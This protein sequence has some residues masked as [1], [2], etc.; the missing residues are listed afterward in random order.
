MERDFR[1]TTQCPS[2]TTDIVGD[3]F[4]G[5]N[6][7]NQKCLPILW[8]E[9]LNFE[10][11]QVEKS[12]S[13]MNMIW[14]RCGGFCRGYAMQNNISHHIMKGYGVFNEVILQTSMSASSVSKSHLVEPHP[15][16]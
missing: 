15:H 3:T 7:L 13:S 11:L 5:H 1:V 4:I 16:A 8:A 9:I 6:V 14:H 10:I 2:C 12:S